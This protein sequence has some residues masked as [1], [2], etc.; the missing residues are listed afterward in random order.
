M[1]KTLLLL[2]VLVA[3]SCGVK[4]SNNTIPDPE[5][6]KWVLEEL[7]TLPNV[8]VPAKDSP[9]VVLEKSTG[10]TNGSGGCNSFFGSFTR[11]GDK[12]DIS[13]L[14]STKKFCADLQE[15]EN[16]FFSAL[17]AANRYSIKGH[18]LLLFKDNTPL[19]QLKKG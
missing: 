2:L 16:G 19:A 18:K 6:I 4:N 17:E 14:A 13:N 11:N 8:Q 5:G 9:F 1:T 3:A 12:L 7:H 10:K 15:L